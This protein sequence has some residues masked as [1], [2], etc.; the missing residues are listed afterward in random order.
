MSFL[1]YANIM[2]GK[3]LSFVQLDER[4]H[5]SLY[6]QLELTYLCVIFFFAGSWLFCF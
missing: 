5:A 3:S 2:T 6:T 4:D 1:E